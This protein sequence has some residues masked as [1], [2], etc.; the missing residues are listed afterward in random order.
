MLSDRLEGPAPAGPS[1]RR[2]STG[3]AAV[4][5]GLLVLAGC[6][7]PFADDEPAASPEPLPELAEAAV[8]L[9]ELDPGS[10]A[11]SDAVT[12]T[13]SGA[14]GP[15]GPT[16]SSGEPRA[17]GSPSAPPSYRTA[18]A[19]ADRRGDAG[20][21]TPA[22]ADA[23]ELAAAHDG[24]VLRVS[25]T[26][27]GDIPVVLDDGEVMGVGI[28]FFAA[29]EDESGYQ[30]FADGGADGWR[31]FLQTPDGFVDYPGRF[32]VG[33]RSLVFEVPWESL[34]GASAREVRTFVDWTRPAVVVG[35][36]GGDRIPDDGRLALS[37]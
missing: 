2:R 25:V 17:V 32:A 13:P 27:A 24:T 12:S 15:G 3:A 18:L 1:A 21:T 9:D 6:T 5:A 33:G 7:S 26:M 34:G 37:P 36:S 31:A 30:L 29:G 28:D 10:A 8:P 23:V 20:L 19:A 4:V 11:V 35:E 16:T 22:H 14:P